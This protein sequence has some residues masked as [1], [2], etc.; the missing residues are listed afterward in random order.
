MCSSDLFS[1]GPVRLFQGRLV[2]IPGNA[3]HLIIISLAFCHV[4]SSFL[5]ARKGAWAAPNPH[6]VFPFICG[7]AVSDPRA[8]DFYIFR[9]LHFFKVP[10]N[11]IVILRGA[12]HIRSRLRAS[13]RAGSS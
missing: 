6:H 11:H 10:V 13:L 4:R 7:A 1:Q 9:I 5:N 8:A 2:R 12:A 3:Q